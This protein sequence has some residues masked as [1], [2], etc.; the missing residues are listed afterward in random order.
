MGKVFI[1]DEVN[2]MYTADV[3][4]AGKLEVETGAAA[5]SLLS[6]AK[7]LISAETVSTAACYLKSLIIGEHPASAATLTIYD[8]GISAGGVSGFGS[9]GANIVATLAWT[10]GAASAVVSGMGSIPKVI[11]INVYLASGL[12]IGTVSAAAPGL[13]YKG[14]MR[15]V[16]VVYQT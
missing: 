14:C 13:G 2:D 8:T 11:P 10:M 4:N 12:T 5:F 6:S 15:N 7:S 9:S 16:T 3:T 1:T